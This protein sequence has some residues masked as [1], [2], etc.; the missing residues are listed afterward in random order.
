MFVCNDCGEEFEFEDDL[1]IH[2][3][4]DFGEEIA[5]DRCRCTKCGEEF[6][7]W[8]DLY[9]H[10]IW[11]EKLGSLSGIDKKEFDE[12]MNNPDFD[13]IRAEIDNR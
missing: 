8:G 2:L 5:N 12:F 3:S 13:E 10:L 7:A 6:D 9:M 1:G 11:G 4:S